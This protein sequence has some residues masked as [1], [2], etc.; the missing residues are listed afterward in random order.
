MTQRRFV[1]P[2]CPLHCDD[3][4]SEAMSAECSLLANRLGDAVEHDSR[5]SVSDETA[6]KTARQWVAEAESVAVTGSAVDLETARAVCRFLRLTGAVWANFGHDGAAYREAFSRDGM[7]LTTLG[8]AAAAHQHVILIGDPAE[9]WPRL[10]QRLAGV[11]EVYRWQ[12]TDRLADRL[13]EVRMR[14]RGVAPSRSADGP[15]VQDPGAVVDADLAHTVNTCQT[16]TSVVFVVAPGAVDADDARLFWKTLGGMLGE[17]NRR[18]R[19]TLLR[20]DDSAT[21]RNVAAWTGQTRT[22]PVMEST[23]SAYDL[24]VHLVPWDESSVDP[25][26]FLASTSRYIRIG[27]SSPDSQAPPGAVCQLN[28]STPGIGRPGVVIRGDGSVTLPLG[29]IAKTRLASPAEV[30]D[31]LAVAQDLPVVD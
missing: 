23:S 10:T 25:P 15:A 28:T 4:D 30:L 3:L 20:F 6:M 24:V 9:S 16:A 12:R 8:D 29:A 21:M 2:F 5:S 19:C 27:I 1:C 31:Q 18:I 13:A 14:L 22:P 26:G 11:T 7:I 17:L